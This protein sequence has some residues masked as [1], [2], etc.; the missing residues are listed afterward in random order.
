[1]AKIDQAPRFNVGGQVQISTQ[2]GWTDATV[3]HV[4]HVD[5]AEQPEISG[6]YYEVSYTP[7]WAKDGF[8]GKTVVTGDA[9][10]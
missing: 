9:V 3:T 7:K 10:R 2:N 8:T 5:I 6:Y 4:N 1:M